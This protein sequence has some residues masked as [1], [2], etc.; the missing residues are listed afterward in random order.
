[1]ASRARN[2]VRNA[3]AAIG[4]N[5]EK[6]SSIQH[7]IE[8][9]RTAMLAVMEKL[10]RSARLSMQAIRS[11]EQV[12]VSVRQ[13]TKVLAELDQSACA[14]KIVA[15]NA[16]IEAVHVRE[17]GK[18]SEVVAEEI[19]CQAARSIALTVHVGTILEKLVATRMRRQLN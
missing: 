19:S 14:N 3:S 2:T 11:M 18:G 17:A 7:A 1:M 12:E 6:N 5:D 9:S 16:K 10:E 15:L 8:E 13:V 4:N